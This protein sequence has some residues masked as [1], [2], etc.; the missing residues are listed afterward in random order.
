VRSGGYMFRKI[1]AKKDDP[2]EWWHSVLLFP[3]AAASRR[4]VE[5]ALQRSNHVERGLFRHLM[6]HRMR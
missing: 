3:G 5:V 1:V 2:E 4:S 6:R